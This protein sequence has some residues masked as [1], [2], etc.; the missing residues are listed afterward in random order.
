[1]FFKCFFL[2][3]VQ[4]IENIL[5][6]ETILFPSLLFP[7]ILIISVIQNNPTVHIQNNPT[8]HIFHS[9]IYLSP[10]IFSLII[11]PKISPIWIVGLFW[12]AEMKEYEEIW[13]KG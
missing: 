3:N 12:I 11:A 5:T 13:E 4:N 7:H 10:I 6:Q 8:V 2:S 1:M 9:L